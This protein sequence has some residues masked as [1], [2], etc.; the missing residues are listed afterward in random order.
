MEV[1]LFVCLG[2]FKSLFFCFADDTANNEEKDKDMAR[3][4]KG[5]IEDERLK[6]ELEVYSMGV[7]FLFCFCCDFFC[8]VCSSES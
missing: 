7:F 2:V 3:E 4:E 8:F 1:F 6:A 5:R